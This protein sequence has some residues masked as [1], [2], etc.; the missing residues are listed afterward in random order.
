MDPLAHAAQVDGPEQARLVALHEGLRPAGPSTAAAT[1]SP[2]QPPGAHGPHENVRTNNSIA[3]H[4]SLPC[5]DLL[6]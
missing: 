3:E 1:G 5:H 4:Y 6:P 2:A